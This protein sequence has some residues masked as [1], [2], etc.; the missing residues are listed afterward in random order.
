MYPANVNLAYFKINILFCNDRTLKSVK[1]VSRVDR[2]ERVSKII[3]WFKK[4]VKKGLK[5]VRKII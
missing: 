5:K 3:I 1:L 4:K 2:V